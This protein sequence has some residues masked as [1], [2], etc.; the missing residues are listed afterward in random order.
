MPRGRSASTHHRGSQSSVCWQ[1]AQDSRRRPTTV[2]AATMTATVPVHIGTR[3]P[4]PVGGRNH[5]CESV[6]HVPAQLVV[7]RQLR[8][9][10]SAR[11]P[12]S[13]PLGGRRTILKS[14]TTGGRIS[15]ELPRDCRRGTADVPS[16]VTNPKVL[17]VQDGDFFSLGKREIAP[18]RGARLIGGMPPLSRNHLVPTGWDTLATSA[19]SSLDNPQAIASQNRRRCSRCPAVGR[20][21]DCIGGRP[22]RCDRRRFGVSI[23]TPHR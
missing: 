4:R 7:C 23:A 21:G 9:L 10:R 17:G 18:D 2:L 8:H 11:L 19:A 13:V 1:F 15:T 12:V 14:A 5:A 3:H 20:P 6:L 16:D 22:A